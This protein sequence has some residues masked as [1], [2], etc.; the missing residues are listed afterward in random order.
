MAKKRYLVIV[1][2]GP[3]NYSAFV[4]DVEG[5]YATGKSLEEIEA[6]IKDA[7]TLYFDLDRGGPLPGQVVPEPTMQPLWVDIEFPE[8]SS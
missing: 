3:N 8:R 4:P 1:E 6:A 7:F 5:V 2:S